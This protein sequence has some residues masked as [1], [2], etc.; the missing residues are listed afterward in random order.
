MSKSV[1]IF[2][3][4]SSC[5]TFSSYKMENEQPE[6]ILSTLTVDYGTIEYN[7]YPKRTVTVKNV[8]DAPLLLHN[9]KVSDGGLGPAS[10]TNHP[11]LPK[12]TGQISFRYNTRRLGKFSKSITVISNVG[13]KM[14]RVK[15]YVLDTIQ[16][17]IQA[18]SNIIDYGTIDQ[19]SDPYRFF[20]IK[21]IGK[22]VLIISRT[23][24]SG[25]C[26][27]TATR[28]P[29]SPNETVEIKVRYDTKRLGKFN[30]SLT[31]VTNNEL[32]P[33]YVIRLKGTVKKGEEKE[34]RE[35]K[36]SILDH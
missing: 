16:P 25:S 23:K 6:M 28:T 7:S 10:Y 27:A 29:I 12:E 24:C 8:G 18:D 26:V 9:V 20:K 11:I 1:L 32:Q 22:K 14:I 13:Q 33:N 3:I 31:L 34:K 36:K 17:K 21:N 30:R 15:G 2:L 19:N 4:I 5:F 35:I